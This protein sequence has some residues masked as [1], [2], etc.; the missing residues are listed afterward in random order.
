MLS[1]VDLSRTRWPPTG[2]YYQ[3]RL[4]QLREAVRLAENASKTLV[5]A[6]VSGRLDHCNSL[7]FGTSEGQMNRLQSVQNAATHLVKLVLDV[8][9]T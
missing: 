1:A 8:Q 3:Y 4:R 9:T 5:Q 6:F 7:L 2:L